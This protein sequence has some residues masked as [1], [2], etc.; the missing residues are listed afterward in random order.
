MAKISDEM[1]VRLEKINKMKSQG[2][3]PY[4][5]RCD[6]THTLKDAGKLKIGTENVMICGRLML[7]RVFGKLI[8]ATIQDY[9]GRLQI[10]LN[11][12]SL[13]EEKFKFFQKMVDVGDFVFSEGEIFKTQ[14]GEVTLRVF[15]YK[16]L[17]KAIRPLPEKFH[18]VTDLE[19]K[20]RQRY[21][22]LIMGNQ[23]KDR[24]KK[25]IKIIKTMRNILDSNN[26][27]EVET[28]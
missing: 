25:R 6:K 15:K 23:T 27:I 28:P 7:K 3:N 24:F 8:F 1:K 5:D 26:F 21:L 10:A 20:S 18:G 9:T 16:L 12:G 13:D 2:I 11:L 22:D 19:A 14:K 17:S 4:L